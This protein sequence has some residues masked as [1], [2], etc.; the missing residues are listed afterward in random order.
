MF[1]LE[2][3]FWGSSKTPENDLATKSYFDSE[4]GDF[5]IWND[6]YSDKNAISKIGYWELINIYTG[7]IYSCINVRANSLANLEANL[8]PSKI[9]TD[10]ILEND[11]M[12]LIDWEL[13]KAMSS[14][15]DL[16]GTCYLLKETIGAKVTGFKILRSDTVR[17]LQTEEGIITGYAFHSGK[18]TYNFDPNQIIAIHQF[19]PSQSYPNVTNWISPAMA[20]AKQQIMDMMAVEYNYLFFKEGGKPGTILTTEKSIDG[21]AKQAIISKWNRFFAGLRNS[22][23]TAIL[24]KWLKYQ[25]TTV[26][27]KEM[28]FSK[29]REFTREEILGMFGVPLPLL[30]K[31]DGVGFADRQVPEYYFQK[32]H[33]LPLARQIENAFNKQLFN[34]IGF[35]T[36]GNIVSADLAGL[37]ALFDQGVITINELRNANNFSLVK[38]GDVNNEGDPLEIATVKSKSLFSNQDLKILSKGF[39]ALKKKASDEYAEKLWVAMAK[40]ADLYEVEMKKEI[41]SIWD[42]QEKIIISN[43]KKSKSIKDFVKKAEEDKDEIFNGLVVG[44]MWLAGKMKG[45]IKKAIIKEG[46]EAYKL[47]GASGKF[48]A[49][50]LDS[51]INTD[52]SKFGKQIDKTTKTTILKKVTEGYE[53]GLSEKEIIS[54]IKGEFKTFKKDRLQQIVRTESTKAVG[55]ANMEAYSQ[56][57]IE[58]KEWYTNIDARTCPHCADMHG[59]IIKTGDSFYNKWDTTDTGLRLEYDSVLHPPL[60]VLCRCILLPVL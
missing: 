54:D 53:A 47:T 43:I 9:R 37:G 57:G 11:T 51:W 20:V 44:L 23:K 27:Q 40:R 48:D 13:K 31:S 15:L 38:Q 2:K 22:H 3:L 26:G 5:A 16:F 41:I 28:E 8:H 50:K 12:E 59:K 19:N 10:S 36:F 35:F 39:N 46:D 45:I 60:H 55:R 29:Q 33:L 30:W 58:K 17:P 32:Y 56:A 24:D 25:A 34:G 52:V 42:D 4:I 7:W 6:K 1:W 14:V 49:D 18:R 21:D